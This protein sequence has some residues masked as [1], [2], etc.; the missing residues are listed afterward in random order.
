MSLR[1]IPALVWT[2]VKAAGYLV[3]LVCW[4]ALMPFTE[5]GRPQWERHG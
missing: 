5:M 3:W 1:W 2:V 4:L